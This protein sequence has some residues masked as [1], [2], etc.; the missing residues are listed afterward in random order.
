MAAEATVK[1][2][3]TNQWEVQS[4]ITDVPMSTDSDALKQY[5]H[6]LPQGVHADRLHRGHL[7][8]GRL[9]A[10]PLPHSNGRPVCAPSC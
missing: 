9:A 4:V 2:T 10:L 7:G 8:Y 1:V 3:P 5:S 6:Q